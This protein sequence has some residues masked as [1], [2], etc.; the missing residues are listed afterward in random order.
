MS[1]KFT[2]LE[3]LNIDNEIAQEV[4]NIQK[5]DALNLNSN[6]FIS[7]DLYNSENN[8]WVIGFARTITKISDINIRKKDFKTA[9]KFNRE[10]IKVLEYISNHFRHNFEKII[11][12]ILMF[13]H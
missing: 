12:S 7:I 5:E 13:I 6:K 3:D 11:L 10:S 2:S 4:F 1:N 8:S 9:L